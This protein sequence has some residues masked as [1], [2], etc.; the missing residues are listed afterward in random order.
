MNDATRDLVRDRAGR[1][2]EYCGLAEED[3]AFSFHLEHIV[4]K[5]HGG[6]DS[7][8]NLALA[9]HQCNLHKGTN[10]AGIDPSTQAITRLFHPREDAW[11]QHFRQVGSRIE[12]L[13]AV[14]RTTVQVLNMNDEDRRALRALLGNP[15]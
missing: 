14:G 10:I 2:C 3:D 1:R 6:D 9:C 4:P 13:S 12:G 5:K 8:S 15:T 11:D 7:D